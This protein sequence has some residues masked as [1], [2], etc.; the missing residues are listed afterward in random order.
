M[1]NDLLIK[2][3]VSDLAR[4][5]GQPAKQVIDEL[6]AVTGEAKKPGANLS[7]EELNLVMDQLTKGAQE[8]DLTAYFESEQKSAPVKAEKKAAPKAAEKPAAP[9]AKEEAAPVKKEEPKQ[10]VEPAAV[11]R[12]ADGSIV[13]LAH[14]KKRRQQVA[15]HAQEVAERAAAEKAAAEKAAAEKAAAEKAAAEAAAKAAAEKAAAEK[16]AA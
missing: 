12:R 14:G 16:A 10:E 3:K 1:A 9:A 6:A 13:E 11:L 2:Y 5:L 4:D 15:Q 7:K 8:Q